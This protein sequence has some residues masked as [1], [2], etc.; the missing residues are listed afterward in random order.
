MERQKDREMIFSF[1]L[2]IYNLYFNIFKD[3]YVVLLL[4]F[5][6]INFNFSIFQEL[7]NEFV[8]YD[9][10]LLAEFDYFFPFFNLLYFR[11]Q[12]AIFNAFY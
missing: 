1:L 5:S 9:L 10:I 4:N 8:S 2:E 7:I 6:D 11:I 12:W 3:I